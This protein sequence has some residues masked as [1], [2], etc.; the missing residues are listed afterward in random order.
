MFRLI[1]VLTLGISLTACDKP[2]VSD[3][4]D[5]IKV[6]PREGLKFPDT[7]SGRAVVA[8]LDAIFATGPDAEANYQ[9]S[10]TAL[11]TKGVETITTI[12]ETYNNAD[13]SLYNE[14]AV[15]VETLSELRL[16]EARDSLLE[17]ANE[18]LPER[19]LAPDD[20]FSAIDQESIIRMTAIRGLGH[21]ALKDDTA[22]NALGV[23]AT[24]REVSL[25]EQARVSFAIVIAQEK[26]RERLVR[27]IKLFPGEYKDWL[28]LVG[29]APPAPSLN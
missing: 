10:L 4:Q 19:V 5:I 15:L 18:K 13:K 17:I 27:L 7:D 14:R 9:A 23:L 8:H 1:L 28:P 29:V 26:D 3:S 21:I 2:P 22:A 25:Q 6:T 24:H 20:T 11:R 16:L 12:V